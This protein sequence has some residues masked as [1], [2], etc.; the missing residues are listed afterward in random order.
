[1]GK[2]SN[3]QDQDV[4]LKIYDGE[5]DRLTISR[6]PIILWIIF[7][8]IEGIVIQNITTPLPIRSLLFSLA[9]ALH[10]LLYWHVRK[11]LHY[12]SWIFLLFKQELSF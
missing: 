5:G 11:I 12:G 8:Y 6:V 10:V 3:E 2:Q 7:I 1:M 9:I 4:D